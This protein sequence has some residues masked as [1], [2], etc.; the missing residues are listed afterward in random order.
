MTSAYAWRSHFGQRLAEL[1]NV[2][3]DIRVCQGVLSSLLAAESAGASE[4][5]LVAACVHYRRAFA[6]KRTL[7]LAELGRLGAAD[8]LLHQQVL[9]TAELAVNHSK[10][11][12]DETEVGV[13]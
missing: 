10:D 12:F 11:P 13:I 9:A 5:L 1:H 8:L 6:S 7:T 3:T 2:L 4:Q